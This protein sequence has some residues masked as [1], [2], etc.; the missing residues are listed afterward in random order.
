MLV[1]NKHTIG[2]YF[3]LKLEYEATISSANKNYPLK[4]W[5]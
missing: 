4:K 5:L 3:L 2:L 1:Y